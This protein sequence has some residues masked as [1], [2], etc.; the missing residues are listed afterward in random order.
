[1]NTKKVIVK[2]KRR[3][4]SEKGAS[5]IEA[6][7]ALGIIAYVIV[8]ILSGMTQ[9]HYISQSNSNRNTA[10]ML[11]ESKLESV[12]KFP[13]TQLVAT[14]LPEYEFLTVSSERGV[15]LIQKS[16]DATPPVG[17]TKNYYRRATTVTRDV[18]ANLATIR[19][20]VEFEE[21][22]EKEGV[23]EYNYHV[24]LSSRRTI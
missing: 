3:A 15:E 12:L 10:M 4:N 18:I 13:V 17:I 21:N 11:A 2:K 8:A 5:L 9:Y 6:L 24:Q 23:M 16:A 14:G 7:I 22:G 20:L 1:M 19:V